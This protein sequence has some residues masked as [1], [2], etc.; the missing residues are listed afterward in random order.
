MNAVRDD[1]ATTARGSVAVRPPSGAPILGA[2]TATRCPVCAKLIQR[3]GRQRFCSTG[4][5]QSAWRAERAAPVEP[6]VAKSDTVYSCPVCEARYL[7]EQRCDTCNLWC[8]RLGPGA[9][10]PCCDAPISITELL[11]PDQFA[12]TAATKPT[13]RR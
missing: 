6:R 11:G 7:G 1:T 10:C 8:R 13:R 9:P 2:A 3:L 5:R 12:K 4:C